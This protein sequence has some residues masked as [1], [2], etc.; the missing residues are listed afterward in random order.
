M[1]HILTLPLQD[2]GLAPMSICSMKLEFPVLP[3]QRT[4]SIQRV[5]NSWSGKRYL[6]CIAQ[7]YL[8]TV[9]WVYVRPAN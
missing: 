1:T 3:L 4:Y 2:S 6:S 8:W 7:R 9:Y 5:I